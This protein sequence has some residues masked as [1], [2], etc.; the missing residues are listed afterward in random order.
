MKHILYFILCTCVLVTSCA[1]DKQ[2]NLPGNVKY[3]SGFSADGYLKTSS[4]G[5]SLTLFFSGSVFPSTYELKNGNELWTEYG[6]VAKISVKSNG[7]IH[8]YNCSTSGVSHAIG[9]TWRP[10]R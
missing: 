8:I 6:K 3:S 4:N 10:S 5:K 9:G 7:N 2:V 1:S